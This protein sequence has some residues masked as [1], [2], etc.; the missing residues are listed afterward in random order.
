MCKHGTYRHPSV[1]PESPNPPRPASTRARFPSV[2]SG[3]TNYIYFLITNASPSPQRAAPT[4]SRPQPL[5]RGG[6]GRG[7]GRPLG[8]EP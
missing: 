7:A 3:A 2:T 5:P 1:R 8:P 6:P 4:A